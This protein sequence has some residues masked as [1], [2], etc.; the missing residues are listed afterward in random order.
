MEAFSND[1]TEPM[2]Q[3]TEGTLLF[4]YGYMVIPK[5][6][7]LSLADLLN[8]QYGRRFNHTVQRYLVAECARIMHFMHVTCGAAHCDFKIDNLILTDTYR[9]VAIDFAQCTSV[10]DILTHKIGTDIFNPP[11]SVVVPASGYSAAAHDYFSLGVVMVCI[12][13][14]NLPFDENSLKDSLFRK[15]FRNNEPQKYF[16]RFGDKNGQNYPCQ[17]ALDIVTALLQ[18]EPE[19]RKDI[20]W[21]M[22]QPYIRDAPSRGEALYE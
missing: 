15:A 20:E 17:E 2:L 6:G 7:S 5:A 12:L 3:H 9:L 14:V 10:E 21:V 19:S 16:E 11:E 4:N 1:P 22:E 8:I 13:F 18:V